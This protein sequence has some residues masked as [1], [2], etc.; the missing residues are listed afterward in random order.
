MK[1]LLTILS[2]P[3]T[4][5]AVVAA[6]VIGVL[7]FE[8]MRNAVKLKN[9]LDAAKQEE[10]KRLTA[11]NLLVSETASR[12]QVE[13]E[14]GT[15]RG[16]VDS[17]ATLLGRKPK[18]VEVVKWRTQEVPIPV[19]PVD[20]ECPDGSPAPPCPPVA[21]EVAGR[22]ARLETVNGNTVAL[23]EIDVW[24]TQP[25]PREKVATVPWEVDGSKLVRTEKPAL[26][27]RWY[28][29]AQVGVL[30]GEAAVGPVMVGPPLRL[31]RVE[32]RPVVGGLLNPSWD[33]TLHAGLV[34]GITRKP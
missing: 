7:V 14:L 26:S 13:D 1:R 8:D 32:A 15:L 30:G 20:R 9:A 18:V 31:F 10:A 28:V 2:H 6:V 25:L 3:I 5:V 24:R 22:E 17:M 12:R 34:F 33:T 29:G 27:P 4:W 19:P 11:E 21:I 16:Q 23:G